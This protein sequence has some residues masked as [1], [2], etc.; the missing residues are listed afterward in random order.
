[1][2]VRH[3]R[4]W[5]GRASQETLGLDGSRRRRGVLGRVCAC[6]NGRNGRTPAPH[7]GGAPASE[8]RRRE[9]ASISRDRAKQ[10]YT[11]L[12]KSPKPT[13]LLARMGMPKKL[14]REINQQTR[15]VNFDAFRQHLLLTKSRFREFGGLATRKCLT[16]SDLTPATIPN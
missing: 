16:G 8:L 4:R 1:M 10:N 11:A 3:L 6:P 5:T 13:W 2:S 12:M 7:N 14:F 15:A 9:F